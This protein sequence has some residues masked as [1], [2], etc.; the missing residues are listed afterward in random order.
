MFALRIIAI[1]FAL[2]FEGKAQNL[3][4][5]GVLTRK[6]DKTTGAPTFGAQRSLNECN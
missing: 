3:T 1:I 2:P 5:L 6:Q 4:D